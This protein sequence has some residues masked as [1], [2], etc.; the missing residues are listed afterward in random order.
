M[1]IINA[2]KGVN[3]STQ[4]DDDGNLDILFN[5]IKVGFFGDDGALHLFSLD[6]D[7]ASTL[8]ALGVC[9]EDDRVQVEFE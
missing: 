6:D 7:E 8:E 4:P 3:I 5:T 2:Q 9:I 1:K